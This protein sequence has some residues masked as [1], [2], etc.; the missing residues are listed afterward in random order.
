[1]YRGRKIVR[2]GNG[3]PRV[4]GQNT[5]KTKPMTRQQSTLLFDKDQTMEKNE[6][7][8]LVKLVLSRELLIV[9][10]NDLRNLN[11]QEK[12]KLGSDVLVKI[13]E[14][15]LTSAILFCVGKERDQYVQK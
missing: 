4:R 2:R 6:Q 3:N 1:M 14:E 8:A 15:E 11:K 9:N 10:Y 7:F 12:T 5:T 13:N